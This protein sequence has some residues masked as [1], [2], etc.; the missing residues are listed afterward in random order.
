MK[1]VWP[2][3]ER[4][5]APILAELTRILPSKGRL[6]EIASGTGQHAAHFAA[7][8]P[9]I[10]WVPSELEASSRESIEAYRAESGL[11]NLESPIALDVAS[12]PWPVSRVDA[13]FCANMI[14]IA[15]FACAASLFQGAGMHLNEGGVLVL[16]GP[17]QFSGTFTSESNAAFDADLRSRDA[18]WGVRDVDDLDSLA[19]EAGL[20]RTECVAMPAN[21]HLLVFRRNGAS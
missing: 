2:A 1:Q 9:G 20:A 17:F 18:R 5:K 13:I 15:P 6:L 11:P 4:N 8:L 21:N 3:P 12:L 10:T 7:A 16:Y 19:T 14:H